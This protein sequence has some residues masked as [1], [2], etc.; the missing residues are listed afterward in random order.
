MHSSPHK[1]FTTNEWIPLEAQTITTHQNV[2]QIMAK[3]ETNSKY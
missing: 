2:K 1:D 3:C